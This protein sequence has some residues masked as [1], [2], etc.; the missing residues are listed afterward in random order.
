MDYI[1]SQMN[2]AYNFL[3]IYFNIILYLNLTS[4]S[5]HFLSALPIITSC[6]FLFF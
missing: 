3:I 1:L 5:D 2:P 6:A 4:L